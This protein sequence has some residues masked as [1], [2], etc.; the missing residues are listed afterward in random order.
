MIVI[1]YDKNVSV[2]LLDF[3]VVIISTYIYVNIIRV[4]YDNKKWTVK[5]KFLWY[6]KFYN[7]IILFVGLKSMGIIVEFDCLYYC[8]YF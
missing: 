2:S 7:H 6:P 5:S 3:C 8:L 4:L 1:H